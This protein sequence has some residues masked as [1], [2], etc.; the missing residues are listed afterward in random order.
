[1]TY[2]LEPL[3]HLYVRDDRFGILRVHYDSA[4]FVHSVE[5]VAQSEPMPYERRRSLLRN[6]IEQVLVGRAS[7]LAV[8][9]HM[10]GTQFQQSVWRALM[11][12]P[13]GTTVTYQQLAQQLG[14]P[15]GQRAVASAVAAN[16]LALLVPCHRVVAAGARLGGFRWGAETKAEWLRAETRP[17]ATEPKPVVP[18][19]LLAGRRA[20]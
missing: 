11:A 19:I 7:P 12:V 5:P 18:R 15:R 14:L 2:A 13:Y 17:P 8:P 9:M 1:M 20:A 6:L 4:L 16:K 3:F 10:E